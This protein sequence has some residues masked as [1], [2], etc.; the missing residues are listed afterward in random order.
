MEGCLCYHLI[1][2]IDFNRHYLS[3]RCWGRVSLCEPIPIIRSRHSRGIAW[4][5]LLYQRYYVN[6]L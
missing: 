2:S 3:P 4:H 1:S 5:V 6:K